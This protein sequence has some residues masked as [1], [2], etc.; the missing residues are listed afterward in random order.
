MDR[1]GISDIL[2]AGRYNLKPDETKISAG[3]FITLPIGEEKVGQSNLNF[4]AF[5]ALRHPLESGMVIT[6]TLGID[7]SEVPKR[8]GDDSDYETSLNIGGGVIYPHSDQLSIIGEIGLRTE[9]DFFLLSGGVDYNITSGRV[10]GA[11][12]VGLDDGAPD[13]MLLGSYLFQF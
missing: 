4:G 2:I 12:G 9:G 10:R 11:L 6:G 13:V 7:F 8:G 5:G 3:G 1:S